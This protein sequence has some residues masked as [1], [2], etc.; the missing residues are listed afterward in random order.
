MQTVKSLNPELELVLYDD[1]QC[2]EFLTK[3]FPKVVV[4]R[5]YQL[6]MGAHKADLFRYCWLYINGGY[7][8]DIKSDFLPNS[9]TNLR[10]RIEPSNCYK[11]FATV[12]G[13]YM[14][15]GSGYQK[16]DSHRNERQLYNG[17]IITPAYNPILYNAIVHICS[18]LPVK[19]SD[20]I[21]NLY[22]MIEQAA[23]FKTLDP[24][25]NE[26]TNSNVFLAVED[27]IAQKDRWYGLCC[28]IRDAKQDVVLLNT[29]VESY[30]KKD[31]TV[32]I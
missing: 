11:S 28:Q 5:F 12:I 18:V 24:G 3:Y 2:I 29:R 30:G 27:C 25:L 22:D 17:I 1:P 21:R 9:M 8:A 20:Y 19:Y 26:L 4:N 14:Y 13:Q 32:W 15:N 10:K 23:A 6:E 7:Y 31:D 16:N